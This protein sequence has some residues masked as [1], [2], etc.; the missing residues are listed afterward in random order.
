ML[1]GKVAKYLPHLQTNVNKGLK[2]RFQESTSGGLFM[3]KKDWHLTVTLKGY[4]LT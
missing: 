1:H 3:A 4:C 2:K